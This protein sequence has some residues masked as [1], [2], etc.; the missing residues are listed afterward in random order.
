MY[1]PP[2]KE[3]QDTKD[4]KMGVFTHYGINNLHAAV[5]QMRVLCNNSGGVISSA[6]GDAVKQKIIKHQMIIGS[7]FDHIIFKIIHL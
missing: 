6:R 5:S 1:C 2:E 7:H 4:H 3:S